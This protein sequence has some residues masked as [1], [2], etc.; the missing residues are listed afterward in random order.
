MTRYFT[1]LDDVWPAGLGRRLGAM[2]YDG[3]L[4][5]AIWVAISALHVLVVRKLL[6]LPAEAVGQGN[7]QVFAL[8][9]A[10][11]ASAFLF[12]AFFW[13]RGGMT[14]GM[15]AWRLRVQS[16]DGS[17]ISLRQAMMRF[18]VG[19]LSFLAFGLGHLWV[20]FDGQ[21]RSWSDMASGSQVVVLPKAV[22]A[23]GY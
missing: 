4:V 6:G 11:L 5:L 1:Q 20:M 12:F 19:A 17:P 10:M 2:L 3:F 9:M 7:W 23:S 21:R 22:K 8:R 16:R 18:V 15:Q 14:L 13:C